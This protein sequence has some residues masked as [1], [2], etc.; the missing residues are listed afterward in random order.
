MCVLSF[1]TVQGSYAYQSPEGGVQVNYV[2]D[3]NG[4]QPSGNTVHPAIQKAVAQQVA[5]AAGKPPVPGVV[6]GV[7]PG[8]YPYRNY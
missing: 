7:Y 1:I 5:E 2:A 6:P 4:F 8:V 3:E